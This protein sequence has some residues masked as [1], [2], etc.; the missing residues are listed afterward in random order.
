MEAKQTLFKHLRLK[1]MMTAIVTSYKSNL[2]GTRTTTQAITHSPTLNEIFRDCRQRDPQLVY[3]FIEAVYLG[4]DYRNEDEVASFKD[5]VLGIALF[6][7]P[8]QPF[9][10]QLS[11][12][13][14]EKLRTVISDINSFCA[15][16]YNDTEVPFENLVKNV[17]SFHQASYISLSC[18]IPYSR[19]HS[20]SAQ[21]INDLQ[22][23]GLG[24]F[25]VHSF[26]H[27]RFCQAFDL[28]KTH[29]GPL[30]YNLRTVLDHWFTILTQYLQ[31]ESDDEVAVHSSEGGFKKHSFPDYLF[32]YPD[33]RR[34]PVEVKRAPLDAFYHEGTISHLEIMIQLVTYMK[35]IRSDLSF[36]ITPHILTRVVFKSDDCDTSIG[37][38]TPKLNVLTFNH[39]DDS[40]FGMLPAWVSMINDSHPQ[41]LSK[42]ETD[43]LGDVLDELKVARERLA[44]SDDS[45]E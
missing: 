14:I 43:A 25:P 34:V 22:I 26:Y 19:P 24:R 32:T 5:I 38:K 31:V 1:E 4:D 20:S 6:Y 10:G 45:S 15:T 41:I 33:G 12:K 7:G 40:E 27:A 29:V 35:M 9:K 13:L 37:S 42:A 3:H 23:S 17:V 39:F 8:A 44:E 28:P 36:L 30:E 11:N 21:I 18:F 2:A 16:N